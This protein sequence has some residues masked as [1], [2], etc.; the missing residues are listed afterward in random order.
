MPAMGWMEFDLERQECISAPLH[1]VWDEIDSLERVLAK[2]PHV[3]V[4]EVAPSKQQARGR[5]T[6]AWGPVK[7]TVNL[8]VA[9]LGLVAE[10]QIRYVIEARSLETSLEAAI[11]LALAGMNETRVHYHA[12][13]VVRHPTARRTWRLLREIAE[14]QADSILHR[15]KVK[16]EQRRLAH[17]RLLAGSPPGQAFLP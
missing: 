1:L 13:V 5:A 9:L 2:T 6:V 16:S 11:D 3:T 17:E 10:Q 15:I 4:C 7:R 14:E 12:S 8:D